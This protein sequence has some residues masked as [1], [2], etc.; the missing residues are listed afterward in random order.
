MIT[1]RE[2]SSLREPSSL[3]ES[4]SHSVP[5]TQPTHNTFQ[6][7]SPG[8]SRYESNRFPNHDSR[9]AFASYGNNPI[10]GAPSHGTFFGGQ[11]SYAGSSHGNQLTYSSSRF[12]E[13]ARPRNADV[14]ARLFKKVQAAGINFEK[15]AEIPVEV[16]GQDIPAPITT[17]NEC[18]LHPIVQENVGFCGY[19]TA[20]PVQKNA[21]PI[22]LKGRD[23]MACA[24]TGSGKT[25]A[26]LVP[27]ISELLIKGPQTLLQDAAGDRGRAT[28]F[29]LVLA[30]TREL[31]T[32]IYEEALKFAYRSWVRPVVVYGGAEPRDQMRQLSLGADILVATPGRLVDM[33]D[34]GKVSLASIKYFV[35]DEAD[36]MLDMGFEPDIRRIVEQYGMPV[37]DTRI[38]A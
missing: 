15:Y 11:S 37:K 32:Q 10:R 16:S 17:F 24:Q 35:L 2:V 14:E 12:H 21:F 4:S 9:P 3:R 38:G 13:Q 7:S 33:I 1:P 26:F 8:P 22:V 23:L 27:I 20:T 19:S 29:A 34:R 6:R 28:P 31:A 30:P 36:R 5:S 18:A 25:A